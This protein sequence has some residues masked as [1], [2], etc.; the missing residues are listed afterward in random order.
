MPDKP[1]EVFLSYAH[2]DHEMCKKMSRHL[3]NLKHQNIIEDWYDHK[4]A[5]GDEWASE[6]EQR[7]NSARIILLL[8]SVDFLN[9]EYIYSV[10]LK[11]AIERHKRGEARVIPV[12]VRSCDWEGAPFSHLQALPKDA[13]AV[14]KWAD[15][16]DAF[17]NIVQG[18]RAA[19]KV[20]QVNPQ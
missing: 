3:A 9:S 4:I 7:L 1:I 14:T 8:I 10:E 12:I 17:V 13:L 2:E 20:I 15:E 19:I 16:D 5:P 18:I 11:H 6:I